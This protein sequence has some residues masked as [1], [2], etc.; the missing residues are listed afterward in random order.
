MF[1]EN[2]LSRLWMDCLFQGFEERSY[3]VIFSKTDIEEGDQGKY[4][5]NSMNWTLA[6][7]L[8]FFKY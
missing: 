3:V 5:V 6:L 2:P 4:W 8:R 1:S 7:D